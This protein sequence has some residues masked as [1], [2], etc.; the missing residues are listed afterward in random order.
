M[1][2]V[3]GANVIS[4]GMPVAEGHKCVS[5]TIPHNMGTVLVIEIKSTA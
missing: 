5:K 4:G 3:R 2:R 1:A